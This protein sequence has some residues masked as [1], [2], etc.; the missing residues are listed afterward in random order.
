MKRLLFLKLLALVACLSSALSATA[1]YDF[2][3]NG[4][5]YK[6]TSSTDKT[7]EVTY[8]PAWHDEY[9]GSYES[10]VTIPQTV[11][12]N[13]TTYTVTGIGKNAFEYSG[14][15]TSV[16]IP[17]SVTYIDSYAFNDCPGLTNITIPNAV[18]RID[19]GAF[20]NCLSLSSVTLGTGLHTI[21]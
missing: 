21:G 2:Y 3:K 12:Y 7:V 8:N 10:N 9:D 11:T 16:S 13:S 14:A 19:A 5:Y 4:I 1:A 20:E 17:S 18:S 15:M 6:I